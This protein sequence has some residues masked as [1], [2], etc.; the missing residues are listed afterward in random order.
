MSHPT[1]S[2]FIG[3]LLKMIKR[4]TLL[5]L[6]ICTVLLM[7]S[8]GMVSAQEADPA[9]KLEITNVNPTD[10]PQVITTANILDAF[11]Q[12]VAGLT[13]EQV[14]I[15]GDLEN[16][17]EVVSVENIRDDN[18]PIAVVLA[19]DTSSSMANAPL[20][21]AKQ[22]ARLFVEQLGE[23]DLIS[24]VQFDNRAELALDYTA[25][26]QQV[27]DTIDQLPLGGRTA[28]YD[29]GVLIVEQAAAA[30][31]N[32]RVA[33]LLSDG[34]EYEAGRSAAGP[35]DALQRALIEGVPVYT[36]GLGFGTDR[37]YLQSL[38]E[39]TNGRFYESPTPEELEAIYTE[40]A[41]FLRSQYVITLDVP[42]PADGTVYAFGVEADVDDQTASDVATLFTPVPVPIVS[43][44]GLPDGEL[45][46]PTFIAAE[47]FADDALTDI[48]VQYD[49]NEAAPVEFSADSNSAI[50]EI[51]P[52]DFEPGEHR[53]TVSAV[54]E[55]GDIGTAQADFTVA[56]I[57]P[58]FDVTTDVFNDGEATYIIFEALPNDGNQSALA[59][60]V[61]RV[62]D[63]AAELT[64]LPNVDE[65][66]GFSGAFEALFLPVGETT[67]EIEALSENGQSAVVTS[68]VD[69]PAV[70]PRVR[71]SVR[72]GE[73]FDSDI[74]VTVETQS[75]TDDVTI[76]YQVDG[77]D[78]TSVDGDSFTLDAIALG[79]G[80]HTLNVNVVDSNGQVTS[81]SV[82]FVISDEA[83]PTATPTAT[84]TPTNTPT[85][86]PTPTATP[87]HTPNAT[88]TQAARDERATQ[89]AQAT[90]DVE[91]TVAAEN[92]AAAVEVA[93]NATSTAEAVALAQQAISTERALATEHAISTR[94]SLDMT[95]TA[96]AI[97]AEEERLAFAATRT[98]E[99]E[100]NAESRATLNAIGTEQAQ[101]TLSAA[102][103]S[104]A[105]IAS[106][107]QAERANAQATLN[108]LPTAT[109][110]GGPRDVPS[111]TPMGTPE[112]VDA[113][114]GNNLLGGM[115]P[116]L[117]WGV[118]GVV[119]LL[120]L[121]TII[122]GAARRRRE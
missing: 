5:F 8:V 95:A 96:D 36:V 97:I 16:I 45:N 115:P 52:A 90:L 50:F 29:A 72:D 26:K 30:P 4:K 83:I 116:L 22:A 51:D 38:A 91:S 73:A 122:L 11:G 41:G 6:T 107:V 23:D 71:L 2:K 111:A 49:D 119:L 92:T 120:V 53:I 113:T 42:V 81:R 33:V 79:A 35:N 47:V 68:S 100:E 13:T 55:D 34:A 85:N 67:F 18:L 106:T 102:L 21:K 48:T 40:L 104:T 80:D 58:A 17:A 19:I 25:D 46:T 121:L 88:E 9:P 61:A 24:I 31:I 70:P 84:F 14:R 117:V 98:R 82:A 93:D 69:V 101:V 94:E 10:L 57:P 118:G 65:D 27:L 87:T 99:A 108:A 103:T 3:A 112:E 66:G 74:N 56:A 114:G 62:G 1:L 43:I 12:P 59:G 110:T 44:A 64:L 20:E 75:Q 109:A 28:L 39:D 86:T 60:A 37:T 54:D 105:E 32:R 63:D 7:M 15:T 78:I 76:G 77:G 89:N